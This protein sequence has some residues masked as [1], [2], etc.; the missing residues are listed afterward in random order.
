ME[1]V[2]E[3]PEE[4]VLYSNAPDAIRLLANRPARFVP[5]RIHPYQ[6]TENRNFDAEISQLGRSVHDGKAVVAWFHVVTWRQYLPTGEEVARAVDL[7]PSC[8]SA[9]GVLYRRL[10]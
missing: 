10:E 4:V 9:T 5:G 3:L 7:E 2:R 1:A 6:G 8:T